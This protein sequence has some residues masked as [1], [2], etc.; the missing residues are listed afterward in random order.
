[1]LLTDLHD[2]GLLVLASHRLLLL[3][4]EMKAAF[5]RL[6][7]E[8]FSMERLDLSS[9]DQV[10]EVLARRQ[11]EHAFVSYADGIYALLTSP[12]AS[13]DN[14]P[15]L[16]VTVLQERLIAPLLELDRTGEAGVERNLR[17]TTD[18]RTAVAAVD[19]G[20]AAAAVLLNATPVSDVL[21]LAKHGVRL[22]QKSTY[23]HPKI[24]SGL[25]MYGLR[26]EAAVGRPEC[27]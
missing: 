20:E 18:P 23:F 27:G 3:P 25:V 6:A 26:P 19:R 8:R 13:R 22:P 14:L 4:P 5:C 17:Y 9:P 16:D 11:G 10:T 12:R 2:P 1:V 7:G 21:T 15:L 24:P